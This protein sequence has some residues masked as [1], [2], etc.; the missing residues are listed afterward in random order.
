MMK[1]IL[2]GISMVI[3]LC[4]CIAPALKICAVSIIYR[5]IAIIIGALGENRICGCLNDIGKIYGVLFLAVMTCAILMFAVLSV[6]AV[7]GSTL[8]G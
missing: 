2:G 8:L 5:F 4:I 6:I 3:L 7:T 1:S